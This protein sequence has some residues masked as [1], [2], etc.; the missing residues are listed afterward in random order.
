MA[1]MAAK[2]CEAGV[3]GQCVQPCVLGTLS[4]GLR[5][6]LRDFPDL[7]ERHL[8][9]SDYLFHASG[10]FE[11][12]YA[13]RSGMLK[14][15]VLTE[16]G[17][18]QITGFFLPG[19]LVGLDSV[20][21]RHH[22]SSAVAL[23][24]TVVCELPFALLERHG[25]SVPRIQAA[26]FR[27][28]SGQIRRE[29]STLLLLGSLRAEE[30]LAQFL[31]DMSERAHS[32]QSCGTAIGM[33][34]TREEIGS[35]LGLK[36]ETVSRTLSKMHRDGVIE[37]VKRGVRIREVNKL[38]SIAGLHALPQAGLAARRLGH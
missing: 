13:V 17:R 15:T 20:G 11:S 6:D 22:V 24:E 27:M 21:L 1:I 10:S 19:D 25:Q 34:M 14:V 16:D 12:L 33:P 4:S 28:L 23:G 5:L 8:A 7:K 37:V 36:L 31:I 9:R 32:D 30:R 29:Q 26:L 18:E 38:R 3:C 2:R 35:Y